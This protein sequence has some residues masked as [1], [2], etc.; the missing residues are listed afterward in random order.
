[1]PDALQFGISVLFL[2]A[3][4]NVK[5]CLTAQRCADRAALILSST[6]FDAN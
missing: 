6:F 2:Q 4:S 3:T 5:K 1:M